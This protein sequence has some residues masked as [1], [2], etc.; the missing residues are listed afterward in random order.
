[1]L[2]CCGIRSEIGFQKDTIFVGPGSWIGGSVPAD[3]TSVPEIPGYLGL[4]PFE[5]PAPENAAY[6][7]HLHQYEAA[8]NMSMSTSVTRYGTSCGVRSD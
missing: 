5:N 2:T 6:L 3:F 4:V 1:V 7:R 8:H